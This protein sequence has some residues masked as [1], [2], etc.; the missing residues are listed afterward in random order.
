TVENAP[1]A[2]WRPGPWTVAAALVAGVAIAA[3]YNA[4]PVLMLVL[5][6]PLA[7]WWR[8]RISGQTAC[9][10][11]IAIFVITG[12]GF[13]IATPELIVD[14]QPLVDGMRFEVG[15]YRHGHPPFQAHSWRDNNLFYWTWYL[16]RL[17]FGLLPLMAVVLFLANF[18]KSRS[19]A[20]PVLAS[21]LV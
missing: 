17:G 8:G 21:Y 15:H 1:E 13:V 9:L 19:L 7:A 5:W 12:G 18:K 10:Q 2:T 4:A 6:I 3:K 16:S 20:S 14:A 11:A